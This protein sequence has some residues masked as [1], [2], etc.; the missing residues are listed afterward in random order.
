MSRKKEAPVS[1]RDFFKTGAAVGV[2]ATGLAS[3]GAGE[4][5]ARQ[6][7]DKTSDFVTLGA[8]TAGLAAAVLALDHGASVIMV[9]ENVDTGGH[10]MVSGGQVHLGGGHSFQQKFG[11]KDSAD[12]VFLDW[13]RWDH[14]RSWQIQQ[15][16]PGASLCR[17]ECRDV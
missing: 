2:G 17:R 3:V 16:R 15:S 6:T 10:G 7:W 14:R 4:T 13:V 11:V 8:G 12:Q 5:S 9:E 1:R